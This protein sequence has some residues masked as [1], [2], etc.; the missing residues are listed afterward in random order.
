M[1]SVS[2]LIE[3]TRV[4]AAVL[5]GIAGLAFPCAAQ[6]S[7]SRN[8]DGGSGL[9]GDA[10]NPWVLGPGMRSNYI[11][12]LRPFSTSMGTT[13][14]VGP[15]I[16]S[17]KTSATRFTALNGTS[18]ISASART[19][20]PYPATSYSYW[21][22][23]GAGLHPTEN[24][25]SGVSAITPAGTATVFGVGL[26]DFDEVAIG[27][28]NVFVNQLYAAQVAFDPGQPGRLYVTRVHAA[29]NSTANNTDRSQF[30]LGS[31]D[32]DGNL[33]FRADSFGSA[34]PTS[35]LLVGD[36]YFRIKSPLRGITVNLIDNN[37]GSNSGA[38]DWLL[39]RSPATHT[40]PTAIP[41]DLAGRSV[42]MGTDLLG[43]YLFESSAGDFSGSSTAHRTGTLDHR[44]AP[45]FSARVLFPGSIGTGA[46]LT[47]TSAGGGKTNAITVWG[48]DAN[49]NPT[50]SRT[51]PLPTSLTDPCLPYTWD[52]GGGDFRGYESQTIF[53][54]GSGPV[55]MT[56]DQQG[57]ALVAS[58]V[59]HGSIGGAA[60][61]FDAIAVA[62]FDP[63]VPGSPVSWTNA[64]WVDTTQSTGKPLFGDYG[65]DGAPGTNDAGEGDGV[66]NANDAPIGR[67][68]SL[69]E[70]PFA[71]PGPSLSAPAFDAAG[72][73]Y[74]IASVSLRKRIGSQV[75]EVPSVALVRAVYDAAAFCYTPE[76]VMEVGSVFTGVNSSTPYQV[77]YLSVADADSSSSTSIWSSSTMQQAWNKLNPLDMPSADP[78]Q[79][80]GLVVSAR[81]CY[82]VN[83]D[84]QFE[85]PTVIGNNPNSPDE[86]YNV[87]LYVGF[88]PTEPR[89]GTADFDND[90]DSGTDADIEAFFACLAGNCCP[91][92]QS[93]DF[94]GD[95]DAGTDFDI[96]AFFRV[97]AGGSC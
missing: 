11:V 42:L 50:T 12:D 28:S 46:I 88:T 73:L 87:V 54:G 69:T 52:L 43:N 5:A 56:M 89:C 65:A 35:S 72:N 39:V 44:G 21:T 40:V 90:G 20:A 34:G 96:E 57:R 10:L 31:I 93:V 27:S 8:S 2:T 95:G 18:V 37:G 97:L 62:R 92:C 78:R 16:K 70:N 85:D 29:A 55:A 71:G 38:T 26:M 13:F 22:T 81:I 4:A 66:V 48:V 53:R 84:G 19:N 47:R 58:L 61:P 75:L 15:I 7:T 63:S 91:T 79:L 1:R 59:F 51:V 14:G 45:S 3:K 74:F 25:A 17:G 82:D 80:G 6:D 68:A 77:Q 60:N 49:G 23:P 30:G 33:C 76:V 9:P 32:A 36:N 41:A 94:D 24:I 64:A 86:A 67:L 83:G